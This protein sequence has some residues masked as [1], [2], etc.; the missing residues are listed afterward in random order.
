MDADTLPVGL[1][2]LAGFG[3]G[4]T[5]VKVE[6]EVFLAQRNAIDQPLKSLKSPRS[7]HRLSLLNHRTNSAPL[8]SG[9][10]SVESKRTTSSYMV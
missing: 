3:R 7:T 5:Q 1:Q 8:D 6:I 4:L 2:E 10:P 9:V